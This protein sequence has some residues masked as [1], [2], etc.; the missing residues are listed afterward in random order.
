[1]TEDSTTSPVVPLLLAAEAAATMCGVSR[2]HWLAMLSA[3]KVP[4]PVRLGRRTLWRV[5]ELR[6]WCAAGLPAQDRWH[7]MGGKCHE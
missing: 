4:A 1:M 3:G 5:D 6:A 2:S 7:S